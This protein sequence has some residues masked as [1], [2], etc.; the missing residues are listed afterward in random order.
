MQPLTPAP[1]AVAPEWFLDVE[2]GD[3]QRIV[4]DELAARL[5]DVA[6]QACE[7]LVRNIGLRYLDAKQRAVRRVQSCLPQLFGVHFAKTFVALDRQA[8]AA[9]GKNRVQQLG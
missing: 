3:A 5:D 7:Y 6:H 1:I 4:L 8:L 9:C 2:V